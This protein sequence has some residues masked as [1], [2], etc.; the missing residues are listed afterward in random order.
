MSRLGAPTLRIV[1]I[2]DIVRAHGEAFRR[3][4]ALT[5]DQ[6][7]FCCQTVLLGGIEAI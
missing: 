6:I 3:T 5:A 7:Q 4:H 2:A 1:E